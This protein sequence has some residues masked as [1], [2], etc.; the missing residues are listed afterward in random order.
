MAAYLPA[1]ATESADVFKRQSFADLDSIGEHAAEVPLAR[2]ALVDFCLS[3]TAAE[4]ETSE[5]VRHIRIGRSGARATSA[6]RRP[7]HPAR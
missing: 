6:P 5:I 4:V 7:V 2:A 1:I 3:V